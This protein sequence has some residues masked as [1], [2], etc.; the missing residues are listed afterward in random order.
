MAT[1][2]TDGVKYYQE[3]YSIQIYTPDDR[4]GDA[5]IDRLA[6]EELDQLDQEELLAYENHIHSLL[7][8][9]RLMLGEPRPPL[10][11]PELDRELHTLLSFATLQDAAK[12]R[13]LLFAGGQITYNHLVDIYNA[14]LE[15]E[16]KLGNMI[17][18]KSSEQLGVLSARHALRF[19]MEQSPDPFLALPL[20]LAIP[21]PA[22]V[23]E[24]LRH[25]VCGDKP[26]PDLA[27]SFETLRYLDA[28]DNIFKG[29]IPFRLPGHTASY[30]ALGIAHGDRTLAAAN[31]ITA[32][33]DTDTLNMV[34]RIMHRNPPLT[35]ADILRRL[36]KN[37]RKLTALLNILEPPV[38]D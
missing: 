15:F 6:L 32:L 10:S 9:H 19:R 7:P 23:K 16:D 4:F 37:D 5:A 22:T 28:G 24:H 17:F 8:R 2:P 34:G 14:A 20:A 11:N 36:A 21:I 13:L 31:L 26:G 3:P 30:R 29:I 33:I 18:Y 27:S 1:D 12:A 38:R 25:R 35:R